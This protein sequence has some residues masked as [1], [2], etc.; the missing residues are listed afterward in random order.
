MLVYETVQLEAAA[1]E[2]TIVST[3]YNENT[4]VFSGQIGSAALL[5][6]QLICSL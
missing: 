4:G 1:V 5:V 3:G 6:K 2:N